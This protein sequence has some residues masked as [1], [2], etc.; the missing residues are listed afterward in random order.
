MAGSSFRQKVRG[1]SLLD[2]LTAVVVLS[3]GLLGLAGLQGRVQTIATDAENQTLAVTLAQN[4]LERLR[5]I[6][7]DPGGTGYEKIAARDATISTIGEQR[8]ETPFAL[9]IDVARFR[10]QGEPGTARYVAAGDDV[11]MQANVPEFKRVNIS[12]R[13]AGK[14]GGAHSVALP[15]IVSPAVF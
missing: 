11:P 8:L 10:L 15:G 6:A 3:V 13:W 4:Q 9:H 7:G 12:V 14:T 2:E 5:G 1:S